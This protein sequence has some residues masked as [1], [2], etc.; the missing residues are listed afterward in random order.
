MEGIKGLSL[1]LNQQEVIIVGDTTL[2]YYVTDK[3]H[4]RLKIIAPDNVQISRLDREEYLKYAVN[5]VYEL[6]KK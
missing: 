3:G 4:K 1:G 2:V 6:D 5:K